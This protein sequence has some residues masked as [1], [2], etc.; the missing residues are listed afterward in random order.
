[1]SAIGLLPEFALLKSSKY[2]TSKILVS[3]LPSTLGLI[4]FCR[5]NVL[6]PSLSVSQKGGYIIEV[7]FAASKTAIVNVPLYWTSLLQ[8]SFSVIFKLYVPASVD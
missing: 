7:A 3:K 8:V 4:S 6:K 1:M 2:T 5:S